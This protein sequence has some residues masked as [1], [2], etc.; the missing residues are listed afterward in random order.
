MKVVLIDGVTLSGK[1]LL[2]TE[3]VKNFSHLKVAHIDESS[4]FLPFLDNRTENVA[5]DS[6]LSLVNKMK[7]LSDNKYDLVF[8]ER[9]HL[10]HAV[11][12]GLGADFIKKIESLFTDFEVATILL[13][14]DISL[15]NERVEESYQH[16]KPSWKTYLQKQVPD[17]NFREYY[18]K[19]VL[20]Y[21][22]LLT[23]S[24]LPT[25]CIDSTHIVKATKKILDQSI[26]AFMPYPLTAAGSLIFDAQNKLFLM[27]SSGNYWGDNINSIN[28]GS[29]LS[30]QQKRVVFQARVNG[31]SGQTVQNIARVYGD[32]ANQVQDD[33]WVFVQNTGV[34][35]GGNVN[36]VYSKKAVN[37]TK[38]S[39]ATT[40]VASRED[41]I[42]YTLTVTNSGNVPANSFVITD[43]LSQV[44]PY[45][46]MVDNGGG[47]L[48]GNVLSYP[49]ITIPAGGSVSKSFKVRVKFSLA[50]NLSYTM[51]NTYGNTLSVRINT[52]QVLGAFVAPK[53]GGPSAQ[54]ASAFG[55]LMVVGMTVVRN[56]RKVLELIWS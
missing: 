22:K 9:F 23:Y 50:A 31:A 19:Q 45:A 5:Y 4:T 11:R 44:L 46:D 55:A 53:T 47:S 32:N 39:D 10:S 42:I 33:A 35:Q 6:L 49:G 18:G 51:T 8:V 30:G 28:L 52:P 17:G 25:L 41:Y 24:T 16:R 36:L 14:Y 1:T 15:A 40:V 38:N 43:D 12:L 27:Q 54:M 56:R 21:H 7:E 34:V 37:E 2:A 13:S 20:N 3:L 29:I 26:R 48:S